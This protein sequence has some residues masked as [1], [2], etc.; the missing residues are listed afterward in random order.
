MWNM[1]RLRLRSPAMRT[2]ATF[3]LILALSGAVVLWAESTADTAAESAFAGSQGY[4]VW[5]LVI[6]ASLAAWVWLAVAGFAAVRGLMNDRPKRSIA[7][8]IV[9]FVLLIGV[10]VVLLQVVL[11]GDRPVRV[12]V[13]GHRALILTLT[14]AGAA[15]I[16]PWLISMWIVQEQVSSLR[17]ELKRW[18]RDANRASAVRRLLEMWTSVERSILAVAV[19]VSTVVLNTGALRAALVPA[20]LTNEQFPSTD[21]LLYGAFFAVLLAVAVVPLVLTWRNTA[22]Q[23]VND[24]VGEPPNGEPDEQW[25]KRRERMEALLHL[26]VGMLRSPITALSI[27]SPLLTAAATAFVPGIK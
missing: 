14:A 11:Q 17:H 24:T 22:A 3:L 12:P 27:L 21:V 19:L 23:L 6:G 9:A 8:D 15:A 13:E 5:T 20:V 26:D 25:I 16:A 1:A 10:A 18:D 2:L 7:R 4:R